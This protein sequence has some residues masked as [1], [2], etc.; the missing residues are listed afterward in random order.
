MK[1]KAIW[2]KVS[3]SQAYGHHPLDC[4]KEMARVFWEALDRL[5]LCSIACPSITFL[6]FTP[7]V[8]RSG[9]CARQT[10]RFFREAT[11]S[12]VCV[13]SVFYRE[14]RVP[15]AGELSQF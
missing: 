8:R 10:H 6:K 13:E 3:I 4:N 2:N 7:G 9:S 12:P 14:E 1:E 5:T 11:G 15:S